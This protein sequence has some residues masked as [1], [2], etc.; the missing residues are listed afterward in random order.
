MLRSDT[1]GLL[2]EVVHMLQAAGEEQQLLVEVPYQARRTRQR[3]ED[4]I[5]RE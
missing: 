3:T 4:Y 5:R 2:Q 1:F